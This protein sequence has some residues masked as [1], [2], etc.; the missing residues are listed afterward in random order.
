MNYSNR[1][2]SEK[3]LYLRQHAYQPVDWYPWK[4]EAFSPLVQ[5]SPMAYAYLF[6]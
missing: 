6:I 2:L 4:E 1:L 3:S 5:K